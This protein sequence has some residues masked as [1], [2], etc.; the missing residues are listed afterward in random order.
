MVSSEMPAELLAVRSI[1]SEGNINAGMMRSGLIPGQHYDQAIETLREKGLLDARYFVDDESM[2]VPQIRATAHR[3]K[4]EHG[5]DLIIADYLQNFH[6]VGPSA[7]SGNRVQEV[8]EISRG[9]KHLAK[10][11]RVPIITLAQLSRSVE[12]RKDEDKRP[13]LSD[14]RDSGNI[15][16]DADV[17]AMLY[18]ENYYNPDCGHNITEV[19]I[20]KH[21]NGPLGT[22]ELEFIPERTKFVSVKK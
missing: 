6:G 1:A 8:G 2:T 14:L 7:R 22:V 18:R 9:L 16:Q 15:E 21:R 5:L 17:V 10:E 12:Q 4:R 3:I 20:R 11:L 19:L 13:V